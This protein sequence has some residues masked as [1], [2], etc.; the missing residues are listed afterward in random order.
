[1]TNPGY[2][3]C[4]RTGRTKQPNPRQSAELL[5][6][7]S[8]YVTSR[9]NASFIKSYKFA[10]GSSTVDRDQVKPYM[11]GSSFIEEAKVFIDNYVTPPRKTDWNPETSLFSMW[12]GVNDLVLPHWTG[13]DQGSMPAIFASYTETTVKVRRI[14]SSGSSP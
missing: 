10:K 4:S 14:S 1:M 8:L 5:T 6:R 9:Y 11:L 3:A 12:F 7:Y 2:E 13:D